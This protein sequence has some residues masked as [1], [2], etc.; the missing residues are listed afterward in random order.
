MLVFLL[1]VNKVFTHFNCGFATDSNETTFETTKKATK[2]DPEVN[3]INEDKE[4]FKIRNVI[5]TEIHLP[6]F[7]LPREE[8]YSTEFVDSTTDQEPKTSADFQNNI[9]DDEKAS[10]KI[11]FEPA[12]ISIM[13]NTSFMDIDMKNI[14][15]SKTLNESYGEEWNSSLY[16]LESIA[17][18]LF[19]R[20]KKAKTRSQI[21][22]E[23]L[24]DLPIL[25]CD[26]FLVVL[27]FQ[28][29][30]LINRQ[31]PKREDIVEV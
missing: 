6:Q 13:I 31:L 23:L 9:T 29:I 18:I 21:Y 16:N 20:R 4:E 12:D 8:I 7:I 1:V 19:N 22:V 3:F 17:N 5:T 2:M 25:F 27:C 10:D 24:G 26:I 11:R 30:L 28:L 15:D 14:F